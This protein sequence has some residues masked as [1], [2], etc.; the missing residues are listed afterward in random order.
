MFDRL[1]NRVFMVESNVCANVH[2]RI[3]CMTHVLR[4]NN[5]RQLH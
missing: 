4:M 5:S 2:E 3:P 1:A